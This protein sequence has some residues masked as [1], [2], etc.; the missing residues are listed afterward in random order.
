MEHPIPFSPR[1]L[2]AIAFAGILAGIASAAAEPSPKHGGTLEF[3]VLVEPTDRKPVAVLCGKKRE[4]SARATL[5]DAGDDDLPRFVEGIYAA[6]QRNCVQLTEYL[7][8][9]PDQVV[10]I[11]RDAFENTM[12]DPEFR[13]DAEKRQLDLEI[14]RGAEIQSLIE[15]IYKTPPAVVERVKKIVQSAE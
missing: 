13:A 14:T 12:N 8:L 4:N 7:R 6:M 15:R 3:A 10:E 9:P 11:L 1:R 5:P 2:I